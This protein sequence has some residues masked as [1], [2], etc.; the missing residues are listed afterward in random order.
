MTAGMS[1]GLARRCRPTRRAIPVLSTARERTPDQT[2]GL[3][4]RLVGSIFRMAERRLA[5][6]V[7]AGAKAIKPL[8][9]RSAFTRASERAV[10][11]IVT[12]TAKAVRSFEKLGVPRSD[13]PPLRSFVR[14]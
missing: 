14:S 3:I 9:T 11:V 10:W 12:S 1:L 2:I 7:Q 5:R 8:T 6:T 4:D 13:G